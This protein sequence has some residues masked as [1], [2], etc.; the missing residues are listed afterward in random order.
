MRPILACQGRF[1][2]PRDSE[3]VV[4]PGE[5]AAEALI[6]ERRQYLAAFP[7]GFCQSLDFLFGR[8][9][10]KEREGRREAETVFDGERLLGAGQGMRLDVAFKGWPLIAPGRRFAMHQSLSRERRLQ[11]GRGRSRDE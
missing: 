3:G 11:S 5:A 1:D 8:T 7:Q 6:A 4:E 2:L 10:G 9:V